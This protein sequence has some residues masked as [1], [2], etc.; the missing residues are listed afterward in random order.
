MWLHPWLLILLYSVNPGH[1]LDD[2][3]N[4]SKD[5]TMT[6]L[7]SINENT[8]KE[9]E[10]TWT[11]NGV[12][13][14][15]FSDEK[16]TC[17]TLDI[18]GRDD[19]GGVKKRF[20]K[21][22]TGV[23]VYKCPG[24][25]GDAPAHQRWFIKGRN[26]D[27][28][29]LEPVFEGI[30][31]SNQVAWDGKRLCLTARKDPSRTPLTTWKYSESQTNTW[32]EQTKFFDWTSKQDT[33]NVNDMF[34]NHHKYFTSWGP[35]YMDHCRPGDPS[36]TWLIALSPDEKDNTRRYPDD[37]KKWTWIRPK[38][39]GRKQCEQAPN[40]DPNVD[41]AQY[42]DAW[43]IHRKDRDCKPNYNYHPGLMRPY[44]PPEKVNE[45]TK[46]Q[47]V[48]VGCSPSNW[49]LQR[50]FALLNKDGNI[51]DKVIKDRI[52]DPRIGPEYYD[53]DFAPVD[54]KDDQFNFAPIGKEW[55]PYN[56]D[57]AA[58]ELP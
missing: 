5:A 1:T 2:D 10:V 54:L 53:A 45:Q 49:M 39:M 51:R 42:P 3:S 30:I 26:T 50:N 9:E 44:I 33:K 16:D 27:G 57:R 22:G 41:A 35:V 11:W 12:I 4:Y 20:P 13:K 47:W 8:P 15:M 19:A 6:R 17:L 32:N 25:L 56:K 34:W 58:R 46:V 29:D 18:L 21:P 40:R 52:K 38:L 24:K 23:G 36:Q 28:L 55:E 37:P 43:C 7:S 14:S 31:R 48:M